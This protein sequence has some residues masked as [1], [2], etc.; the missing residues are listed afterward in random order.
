MPVDVL[1]DH[2]RVVHEHAEQQDQAEQHDHV[3]GVAEGLDEKERDQHAQGDDHRDDRAGSPAHEQDEH[4]GDQDQRGQDIVLEVRHGAADHLRHIGDDV[5]GDGAGDL[6]LRPVHHR[7]HIIRN[8]HDVG[9]DAFLNFQRHVLDAVEPGDGRAVLEGVSHRGDV[10]QVDRYAVPHRQEQMIHFLGRDEFGRDAD[11]EL[12]SR[13]LQAAGGDVDVLRRDQL[14]DL[15]NRQ[16]VLG[17]PLGVH[18]Q[19]DLAFQGPSHLYSQ[20]AGDHLELI[21]HLVGDFLEL[22]GGDVAGDAD[23]HDRN[24]R[25]VDLA[26]D[27]LFHLLGQFASS[28][29]DAVADPLEGDLAGHVRRELHADQGHALGAGG[30]D[31]LH[32]ANAAEFLLDFHRDGGLHVLRRH[33]F[34]DRGDRDVRDWDVRERLPR[35]REVAV[36]AEQD[37]DHAQHGDGGAVSNG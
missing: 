12:G 22:E 23:V 6:L 28:Q 10:G 19:A 31:F 11:I 5:E 32:V 3:Q 1:H 29:I 2:D 30:D 34:V 17:D 7:P 36:A 4:R 37:D 8:V 27:R 13:R 33:P 18:L 9:A 25:D 16:V 14:E 20:N 24:L 35:Q 26:D 21:F 15:R